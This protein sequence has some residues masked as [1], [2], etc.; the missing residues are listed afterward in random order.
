MHCWIFAVPLDNLFKILLERSISGLLSLLIFIKTDFRWL[1]KRLYLSRLMFNNL[2]KLTKIL[3]KKINV[4]NRFCFISV[5]VWAEL[6]FLVSIKNFGQY[7][8]LPWD[9]KFM[10]KKRTFRKIFP[11][12]QN[13]L[14]LHC[15]VDDLVDF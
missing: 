15:L 1:R 5:Q 3:T 12:M 2:A 13:F 6:R 8:K 11:S 10:K 9:N 7:K 14:E 4:Y